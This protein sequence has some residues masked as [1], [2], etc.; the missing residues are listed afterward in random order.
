MFYTHPYCTLPYNQH[1]ICLFLTRTNFSH[2]QTSLYLSN[3]F[4]KSSHPSV[5]SRSFYCRQT[6]KLS[7]I[8]RIFR[9]DFWLNISNV[10][11]VFHN[12]HHWFIRESI[13][14]QVWYQN[15]FT[16][17]LE[18]LT[19]STHV[20]W[21]LV[22]PDFSYSDIYSWLDTKH[23]SSVIPGGRQSPD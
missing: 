18:Q 21:N 16:R 2:P 14:F 19:F 9:L 10:A 1:F 3:K 7:K 20:K 4:S 13:A 15:S 23:I 5:F 12:L 22:S 17:L 11:L 8:L 6:F